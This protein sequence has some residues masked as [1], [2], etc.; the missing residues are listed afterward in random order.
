MRISASLLILYVCAPAAAAP[1]IV[2][3]LVDDLG[4]ADVGCFGS[5]FYETPNID[6]LAS[7]G[8]RLTNAYAACQVC[9]PTR[10]SIMTGKY[11]A[12]LAT[13]DYFGALQP[14]GW[15]RNTKLLPAPYA[16]RLPKD[17]T[18]LAEALRG[19]GYKTFFAGKW[20][21]GP[22]GSWPED[23]GFDINKGGC[24]WGQPKGKG[25]YFSPYGNPRL[26][27]GPD[28]EH[29]TRRLADEACRF[30]EGHTRDRPDQPF[31][32]YLSFYTVHTPLM[33]PAPL[34][35]KYREKK[36]ALG[37][38]DRYADDA[39]NDYQ[40]IRVRRVQGNPVYAAMVESLDSAV[41]RVLE[42]IARLGLDEETMVVFT[43]DNGGFS[44][45][46]GPT[47]NTPLRAG[48]GWVYEGGIRE[49]TIV[50]WPGVTK[51]G[52][53]HSGVVT[54]TDYYPTLLEA[55]GL[56]LSPTQHLDGVSFAAGLRGE[57]VARGPIYWHYPHYGNQG[58][59]PSAAIRDGRWKLIEWYEDGRLELFDLQVDVGEQN[60]LAATNLQE[61]ERLKRLLDDWR[62]EVGAR[63]PTPNPG[64]KPE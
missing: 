64:F 7:T 10:A 46:G 63:L 39:S 18:T 27:D 35:K 52:S 33:A 26:E 13:T 16:D 50:R 25:R 29:L 9:S 11:P 32:A 49:P 28:G 24:T 56:P 14:R 22:K 12:R 31:L 8:A 20:H 48:K 43:S 45:R 60:N 62:A 2:F 30:I 19:A 37:I 23:H 38:V 41:G 53:T 17:E 51:P 55:A 47:S 44:T 42:A 3:F 21:L 15:R 54:S 58:G 6:G 1:N 59:S 40:T 34:N 5:T 36:A 61:L 57:A 4:Y